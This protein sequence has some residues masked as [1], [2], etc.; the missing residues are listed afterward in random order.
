MWFTSD[1]AAP[2][3]PEVLAA[4][5]RANAGPAMAYGGDAETERAR[6]MV[7]EVL[8]APQASVEFVGIGT[9]ANAL[10][11]AA[12]TPPWGAVFCHDEAHV[13]MDECGAPEF[14]TGGAKLVS[15][16]GADGRMDGA[17]LEAAMARVGGSVHHVQPGALSLTQATEAGTVYPAAEI[18]ALAAR[19]KAAGVPVHLDGTRFANALAATGAS[20]AEM[21]WKAGVDVLCL[22]F[23]KNGAIGAEAVV[24]FDDAK[25]WEFQLRRKRGG[26]LFSKMRFVAAQVSALLEGGVWLRLAAHANAMAAA[27]AE[28]LKGVEGVRILHPVEANIVFADLPVAAHEAA[29]AKGAA[30]YD[31]PGAQEG[32]V[33]VRLVASGATEA[34]EVEGLIAALKAG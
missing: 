12:L 21:S 22:G 11:L 25:A 29:K 13:E 24:F 28:E 26:H 3:A 27:L 23:S 15:V 7:R 33:R 2:A 8:E 1:N 17:A 19:A 20:P 30:Y 4:L 14:F 6:A 18:A 5:A 32:F 31:M 34:A 16:P 10:A 9:A